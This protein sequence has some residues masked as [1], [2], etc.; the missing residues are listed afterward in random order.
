ME[1]FLYS[2]FLVYAFFIF[3]VEIIFFLANYC[4]IQG[5]YVFILFDYNFFAALIF[6]FYSKKK[7]QLSRIM[8]I[9]AR[10]KHFY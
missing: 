1:I 4:E 6:F 3:D 9:V 10:L 7:K 2:Q 8:G 5:N